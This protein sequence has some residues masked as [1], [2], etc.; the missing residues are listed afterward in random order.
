M[1][2]GSTFPCTKD[3][4][5]RYDT[6]CMSWVP[7]WQ[8]SV[9]SLGQNVGTQQH[10]NCTSFSRQELYVRAQ[11]LDVAWQVGIAH[12][13]QNSSTV[14]LGT[15]TRMG[16]FQPRLDIRMLDSKATIAMQGHP[17]Y[18]CRRLT[19]VTNAFSSIDHTDEGTILKTA[20]LTSALW[21]IDD[22]HCR[23]TSC[24][25]PS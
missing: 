22:E 3:Y 4:L 12:L 24:V 2:S 6:L 20:L 19:S 17:W 7:L 25:R 13:Q 18:I 8:V 10:A 11:F 15:C 14:V 16:A 5:A 9:W 23:P 1:F 21:R